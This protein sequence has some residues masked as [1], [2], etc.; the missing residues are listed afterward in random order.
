MTSSPKL[1]RHSRWWFA[2]I[3]GF[4][5]LVSSLGAETDAI[6]ELKKQAEQGD[7]EAQ[8]IC[9]QIYLEGHEVTRDYSEAAR[10]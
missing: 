3:S 5:L 6:S 8:F 9:G 7:A 2:F 10:W 4:L 1:S